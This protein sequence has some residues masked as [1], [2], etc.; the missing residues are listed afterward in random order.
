MPEKRYKTFIENTPTIPDKSPMSLNDSINGLIVAANQLIQS[1]TS[2]HPLLFNLPNPFITTIMANTASTTGLATSTATFSN[3][4][5]LQ[6]LSIAGEIQ[7]AYMAIGRA[8]ERTMMIRM[9][10]VLDTQ[11]ASLATEADWN[12]LATSGTAMVL[13][14]MRRLMVLKNSIKHLL[15]LNEE[16]IRSWDPNTAKTLDDSPNDATARLVGW[17]DPAPNRTTRSSSTW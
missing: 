8:T 11:M 9:G 6:A 10:S 13:S 12:T 3:T 2:I 16:V 14:N 4:P 1:L 17:T 7:D 15:Q 5:T